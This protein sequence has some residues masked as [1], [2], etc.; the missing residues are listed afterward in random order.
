M[1]QLHRAMNF[2]RFSK[3]LDTQEQIELLTFL[4]YAPEDDLKLI[5][6][7]LITSP[8]NAR[9][10]LENVRAKKAAVISHDPAAWEKILQEEEKLLA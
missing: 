4:S 2:L 3:R 7:L 5:V 10:L 8:S 1:R 6:K 9:V